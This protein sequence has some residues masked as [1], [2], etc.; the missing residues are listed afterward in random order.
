MEGL[1]DV[2][3]AHSLH[4]TWHSLFF[5][6][7]EG[8]SEAHS[9]RKIVCGTWRT[10]REE[11]EMPHS[12]LFA[13]HSPLFAS[14]ELGGMGREESFERREGGGMAHEE[15]F[16]PLEAELAAFFLAFGRLEGRGMRREEQGTRREEVF[17]G[18]KVPSREEGDGGMRLAGAYARR[19]APGLIDN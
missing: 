10:P 14:F 5:E 13:P 8:E 7:R 17:A 16:A 6:P 1:Y 19:L 12:L 9:P 2:F 15:L 3:T 4:L 18:S 11:L